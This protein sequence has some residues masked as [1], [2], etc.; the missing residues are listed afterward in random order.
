MAARFPKSSLAGGLRRP[1]DRE[2]HRQRAAE[3]APDGLRSDDGG[4]RGRIDRGGLAV[5][6]LRRV[7]SRIYHD[8]SAAVVRLA[9]MVVRS[10]TTLL[11]PTDLEALNRRLQPGFA[12]WRAFVDAA[13]AAIQFR[14]FEQA[15]QVLT[16]ALGAF[17]E[18][19]TLRRAFAASAHDR[20]DFETAIE[21]WEIAMRAEPDDPFCPCA[22]SANLRANHQIWQASAVITT[23]L[24]RFPVNKGVITEAARTAMA[25]RSFKEALALWSLAVEDDRPLPDWLHG[26]VDALAQLDRLDEADA[27]LRDACERYPQD[28]GLLALAEVLT[29]VRQ[30]RSEAPTASTNEITISPA[31]L[32][33]EFESLGDN[34]EFG[35]L[36]R[37]CGSEP[38]ALFRYATSQARNLQHAFAT[39]LDEYG[40]DEDLHIFATSY[41]KEYV[42]RSRRYD[43]FEYHTEVYEG[44][45]EL[46]ALRARELRKVGYLKERLILGLRT[47]DKIFVRKGGPY[48]AA[49]DLHRTMR[50]LGTNILLWVQLEDEAH[51]AG[52]VEFVEEGLLRGFISRFP[53]YDDAH[54]F[55]LREWLTICANA[56]AL[57]KSMSGE[58]VRYRLAENRL[59]QVDQSWVIESLAIAHAIKHECFIHHP[60][61]KLSLV[62]DT[63][64]SN[65]IVAR[66]V[67]APTAA[68]SFVVFSVWVYVPASFQ[69]SFIDV[70]FINAP[71]CFL[72]RADLS[73]RDVWQRVWTS[74]RLPK[75]Q[76]SG[77]VGLRVTGRRDDTIYI[78]TWRVE[79]GCVPNDWH[80]DE[81]T[82]TSR[83][84]EAPVGVAG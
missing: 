15:D 76:A 5:W 14:D 48:Q 29:L 68:R 6:P 64:R 66:R 44:E 46:G 65:A 19:G 56:L 57:V 70:Y 47:G 4:A 83:P 51:A 63:Q 52:T 36:Q 30:G 10:A 67:L 55:E 18:D 38:L 80:L 31:D 13:N 49:V 2:T 41:D 12:V 71:N 35:L 42:C 8:R 27:A 39:D 62:D 20:G 32:V 77:I 43:D 54:A 25:R 45:I 84:D 50:T 24:Q 75:N 72:M 21:R 79:E 11:E 34:C 22:L 58:D 37:Y 69:G 81:T 78:S 33:S 61:F 16:R 26:R 53:T 23:A 74:V 7:P 3:N 82:L 40:T 28:T 60:V 17:P 59:V 9:R 1:T 73:R